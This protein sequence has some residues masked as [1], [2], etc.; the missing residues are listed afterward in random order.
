VKFLTVKAPPVIQIDED[1]VE[2]STTLTEEDIGR[3]AVILRGTYLLCDSKI[4][5]YSIRDE[6]A[7]GD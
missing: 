4:E 1:I 5:A 7:K 2:Y 3:W 6:L